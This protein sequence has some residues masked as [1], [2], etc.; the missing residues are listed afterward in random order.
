MPVATKPLTLLDPKLIEKQN[1]AFWKMSKKKQ[2]VEIAKD[3]LLQLKA[4]NYLAQPGIYVRS[5]T[6]N[7]WEYQQEFDFQQVLVTQSPK[8]EVCG[9]GALF[10]SMARVGDRI[11]YRD[12]LWDSLKLV[13]DRRQIDLI[14]GAFEGW[15]YRGKGILEF[16]NK[17]PTPNKRLAAIMRNIIKNEGELILT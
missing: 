6:L 16:Y 4:K 3:V 10:C 1:K 17:Y 13:F 15:G 11:S 2:R 9:I 8:C 7:S 14:E 5:N 12:D